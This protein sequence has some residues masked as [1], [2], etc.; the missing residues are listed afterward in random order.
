MD[1]FI[2][3]EFICCPFCGCNNVQA[4]IL[5]II[6]CEDKLPVYTSGIDYDKNN[7][8]KPTDYSIAGRL[9]AQFGDVTEAMSYPT[10]YECVGCHKI[11]DAQYG[12]F[13]LVKGNDGLY[14]FVKREYK[15]T[16]KGRKDEINSKT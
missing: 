14:S 1:K 16:K 5:T 4:H 8:R 12:K 9:T 11:W 10:K 15:Q 7:N 2:V 13:D 6:T 3:K